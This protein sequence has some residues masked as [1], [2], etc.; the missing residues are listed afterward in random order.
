MNIAG[1]I[2]ELKKK[3][4]ECEQYIYVCKDSA[5]YYSH[6]Q[7]ILTTI[8]IACSVAIGG[9]STFGYSYDVYQL[10]ITA[11]VIAYLNAFLT[12]YLK[13]AD[14]Q[15]KTFELRRL[16]TRFS[17]LSSTIKKQLILPTEEKDTFYKWLDISYTDL[18]NNLPEYILESSLE[19]F[20]I[21]KTNGYN[22]STLSS[23]HVHGGVTKDDKSDKSDKD[24]DK[25]K[26]TD[27]VFTR[28]LEECKEDVQ[29]PKKDGVLPVESIMNDLQ[30]SVNVSPKSSMIFDE[31]L[32]QYEMQRMNS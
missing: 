7:D 30:L 20:K 28:D 17:T 22:T 16:V 25:V 10:L 2:E 29:P 27:Y 3:S 8:S 24:K 4:N 26:N 14:I 1:I 5:S 6:K 11:Q 12:A 19:K 31:N 32:I 21:K 9:F 18:I 13:Y 15:Q 23:I